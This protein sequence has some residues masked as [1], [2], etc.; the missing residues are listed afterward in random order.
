M[1]ENRPMTTF[2]SHTVLILGV[3]LI[4]FPIWVMVVAASHDALRLTQVP[5]RCYQAIS[6]GLISNCFLVAKALVHLF[7]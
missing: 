2:V 6:F 7:I 3:A 5:C 4:V 1:I